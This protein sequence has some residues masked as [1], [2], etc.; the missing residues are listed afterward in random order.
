MAFAH[1]GRERKEF[2]Q[3]LEIGSYE[4]HIKFE[5]YASC[6]ATTFLRYAIDAKDASEYCKKY[7]QTNKSGEYNKNASDSLNH[8]V[9]ALLPS[10]MGHFE[11]F[12][13]SVFAGLFEYS[14]YIKDFDT[15]KFM[16][17]IEKIQDFGINPSR[18]V[19]YRGQPA[20]IGQLLADSLSC[21]HDP[22]KTNQLILAFELKVNFYDPEA[23]RDLQILWQLRHS[24]VHT[25]GCLTL[26]DAQK[27]HKLSDFAGKP[28]VFS[29]T[30]ITAVSKRMHAIVS[31]SMKRLKYS[32]CKQIP[33][34]VID[35]D[36][37]IKTF[38]DVESKSKTWIVSKSKI[39]TVQA[40]P[41]VPAS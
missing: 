14:R 13:R 5:D 34:N 29:S 38:F 1:P 19:G 32:F 31:D 28:L 8:I 3:Y 15:K 21:W 9:V 11:T 20:S 24:I 18:L 30:F 26:P 10:L 40:A 37:T 25:G 16:S 39:S 35:S 12:Q 6:P 33:N 22:V 27:V 7:F 17:R 23:I 36:K 2:Q 4:S 41:T